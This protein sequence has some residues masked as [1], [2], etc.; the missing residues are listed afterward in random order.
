MNPGTGP[1]RQPASYLTVGEDHVGQRIDNFLATRLRGV[2]RARVYRILRRGEVRVNKR[3]IRQDYRLQAGDVVRVP[4]LRLSPPRTESPVPPAI[5]RVVE[6]GILHEDPGL[7]VVNKPT[8]VPVHG[9]TG[10]SHGVI[11]A[12]RALRP[13]APFLELVHRLDRETSGCL[14]VAK[15]RSALRALHESLRE[16]RVEKRYSLL[17]RGRWAGPARRVELP[18]RKNV[19]QGGE[20]MVTPDP[21]GKSALTELAP[22]AVGKT[23]SLLTARTLTG[24]TH[25]IRVH[26]AAAGYPLAGDAKYGDRAFNRAMKVRGLRRLFLHADEMA[27]PDPGTGRAVHVAAPLPD[28]LQRVLEDLGLHPAP[29][30]LSVGAR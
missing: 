7:L 6:A 21:A 22:A 17:V 28:D 13:K 15:R 11:E 29:P 8:G 16:R 18:L 30:S 9:G 12:L 3:R 10:R 23:A 1:A 19:L 5:A 2:P 27:F 14:L 24:R 26:A 20:R 4:P 25:Q